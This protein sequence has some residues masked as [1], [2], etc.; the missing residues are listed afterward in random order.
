MRSSYVFQHPNK[1]MSVLWLALGIYIIGIA[2]VLYIRPLTMFQPGGGTWKEFGL[3]NTGN[4]TIFPFWM[5]V[6]LWAV[7]SYA[8]ATIGSMVAA[9]VTLKS[10]PSES[11]NTSILTPISETIEEVELPKPPKVRVPRVPKPPAA[12]VAAPTR[13]PGYYIL[14]SPIGQVPKYVYY[15]PEPPTID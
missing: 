3:A 8:L 14:D 6:L 11:A 13:L 10:I 4:Y 9:S 7:V 12:P 1:E 15:G 5:F 2:I